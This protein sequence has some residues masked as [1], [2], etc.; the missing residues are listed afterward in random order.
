MRAKN[1]R[2]KPSSS[3]FRPDQFEL[4][5]N[6]SPASCAARM[7]GI[8]RRNSRYS[9]HGAKRILSGP[10][11]YLSMILAETRCFAAGI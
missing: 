5:I 4:S 8:L 10:T 7:A 6:G 3:G 11:A 2:F 9:N 1:T